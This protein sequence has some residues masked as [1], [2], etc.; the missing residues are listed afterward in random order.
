MSETPSVK[1]ARGMMFG[2][3]HRAPPNRRRN[4]GSLVVL[5]L[6]VTRSSALARAVVVSG[7]GLHCKGRSA[8]S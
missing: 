3:L 4:R 6:A 8:S 5:L 7:F 1:A 2:G